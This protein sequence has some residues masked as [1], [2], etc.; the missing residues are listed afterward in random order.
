[1]RPLRVDRESDPPIYE[2]DNYEWITWPTSRCDN[3]ECFN[4][5]LT[6]RKTCPM[7]A[8]PRRKTCHK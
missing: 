4:W 1:M 6:E 5:F 3:P 8:Y 7:C 2:P